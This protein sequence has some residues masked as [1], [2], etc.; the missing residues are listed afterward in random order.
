VSYPAIRIGEEIASLLSKHRKQQLIRESSVIIRKQLEHLLVLLNNIE[1]QHKMTT[2][3][4]KLLGNRLRMSEALWKSG[5]L[6]PSPMINDLAGDA[7]FQAE[8]N[9]RSIVL[10]NPSLKK[11]LKGVMD[12]RI[13]KKNTILI[14]SGYDNTLDALRTLVEE[15]KKLENGESVSMDDLRRII[16]ELQTISRLLSGN[17]L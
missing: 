12:Y 13:R 4:E 6:D 14:K 2:F 1:E 17:D 3:R 16:S 10:M 5:I 11:G 9:S 8:R 15:H 7:G